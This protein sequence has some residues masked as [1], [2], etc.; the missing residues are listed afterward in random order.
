MTT[1]VTQIT[2]LD[3]ELLSTYLTNGVVH[4]NLPDGRGGISEDLYLA[5]PSYDEELLSTL[6]DHLSEGRAAERE[7]VTLEGRPIWLIS[8]A[9]G[10]EPA[11]VYG[12]E[13][14]PVEKIEY[15]VW[16]DRDTGRLIQSQS[17]MAYTDG[18][19]RVRHT[20]RLRLL[21]RVEAPPPEILHLL[22][23]VILP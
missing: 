9:Q 22:D 2:S 7:E 13:P 18:T 6:N 8:V 14:A 1:S 11:Q 12:G 10:Y 4:L 5:A 3:G 21:E 15:R 20:T 16:I 19:S 23:Q 17:V